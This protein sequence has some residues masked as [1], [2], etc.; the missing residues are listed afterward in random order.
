MIYVKTN[1]EFKWPIT[2]QISAKGSYGKQLAQL[3]KA[4]EGQRPRDTGARDFWMRNTR[5]QWGP[6]EEAGVRLLGKLRYLKAPTYT[7]GGIEK[8]KDSN[9]P[10]KTYAQKRPEK[11]L[12]LHTG[13]ISENLPLHRA[14]LQR[15]G[16]VAFYKGLIFN[17]RL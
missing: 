1:S 3:I 8:I 15:L 13:L 10:R 9:R 5:K 16:E 11:T 6:Q 7:S 17:W 14:S 12:G 2:A 4:A